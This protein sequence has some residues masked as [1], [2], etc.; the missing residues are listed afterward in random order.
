MRR[1][2]R[3]KLV[4]QMRGRGGDGV[5]AATVAA[6]RVCRRLATVTVMYDISIII[7][8]QSSG[9]QL[10]FIDQFEVGRALRA[11]ELCRNTQRIETA[12]YRR[13]CREQMVYKCYYFFIPLSAPRPH[14]IMLCYVLWASK[15]RTHTH[16]DALTMARAC[17][18]QLRCRRQQLQL[19]VQQQTEKS[20]KSVARTVKKRLSNFYNQQT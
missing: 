14:S 4:Y 7:C 18:C 5:A 10:Q 15:G 11:D 17:P 1:L 8:N 6:T 9:F 19:V 13:V 2:R 20:N 16:A 3:F 12:I